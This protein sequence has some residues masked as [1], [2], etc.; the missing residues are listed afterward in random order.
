MNLTNQELE[1]LDHYRKGNIV[2]QEHSH[3]VGLLQKKGLLTDGFYEEVDEN[4][5][6]NKVY[7]TTKLTEYGRRQYNN[8]LIL[9]SST[10]TFFHRICH[11]F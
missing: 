1:T 9:R 6:C 3:L 11:G 10:L 4:G 5:E 2:K 8:N 7:P